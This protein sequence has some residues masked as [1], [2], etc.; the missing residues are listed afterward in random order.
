[1]AA[2]F[3]VR[4]KASVQSLLKTDAGVEV[5][6]SDVD[7]HD[8]TLSAD[9]CVLATRLP[10]ALSIYPAGREVAGPLAD[11]LHYNRGLVVQLGYTRRPT[12]PAIGLLLAT[13]E[14]AQIGLIWL[15]HNKNPDRVPAG[16]SLFS[17]YFDEAVNDQYF[18]LGADELTALTS[19]FVQEMFPELRGALDMTHVTRWPLAIPNPAPGIYKQVHAMKSRIDPNDRIQYAGD[20]FTCVGQNSAIYYGRLAAENLI[21]QFRTLGARSA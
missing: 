13:R 20:Y 12:C 11:N 14:Q 8:D 17:V 21:R 18:T 9:A 19:G 4:L 7:G 10:E 1:L 6:Y 15:E 3:P 16:H 2:H 5:H